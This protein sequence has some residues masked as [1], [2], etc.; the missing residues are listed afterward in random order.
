MEL[1]T[2]A[3]QFINLSVLCEGLLTDKAYTRFREV[4]TV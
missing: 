1:L 3:S 4:H 2:T